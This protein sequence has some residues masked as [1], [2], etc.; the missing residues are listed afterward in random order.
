[1][2]C[3]TKIVVRGSLTVTYHHRNN[4][5][6]TNDCSSKGIESISI[7]HNKFK[8]VLCFNCSHALKENVLF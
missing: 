4:K 3:R 6:V 1:M 2:K 5:T 8:K 7:V